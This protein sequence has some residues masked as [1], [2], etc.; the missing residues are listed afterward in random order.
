[1]D[2]K[3]VNRVVV[4]AWLIGIAGIPS[5]SAATLFS[6]SFERTSILNGN[7]VLDNQGQTS[8][9]SAVTSPRFAG[10]YALKINNPGSGLRAIKHQFAAGLRGTATLAFYDFGDNRSAGS[11]F[12]VANQAVSQYVIVL[13]NSGA[14][15][16]TYRI[17]GTALD[18]G[19]RRTAGWHTVEFV[20]TDQGAYVR[21]D[22]QP[23]AHLGIHAGLT[24]LGWVSM[25]RGWGIAGDTY[26]DTVEVLQGVFSDSFERTSILNGNWVLDNQGQTSN[27]SAVTSP[28]FAGTYALKINNPG[29]GLRAI[30]HQ[31]AAGLRGTATLAFYD[32]GD[33]RSAGS[34]FSVANQAVSQYV[35]VLINS[36]ASTY[37]YRI[38]GTALDSGIRRTAGWHTVEFVVTDQGAYVRLD[39]QPL[40]HLGIHAG[41]TELGWVSMGRGWGIAGDTYVDDVRV[42]NLFD[43]PTGRQAQFDNW[44]NEAYRIYRNT[45][46]TSLISNIS[47]GHVSGVNAARGVAGQAM[48]H[49]YYYD[50]D[51]NPDD[52][53]KAKTYIN[54]VID[55]YPAWKQLWGAPVTMN[56]L[57]FDVWW[58]WPLLDSSVRTKFVN[59]LV[60]EANF[61]TWVMN[62]VR[63]NPAGSTIPAE[64]GRRTD[65]CTPNTQPNNKSV[66]T[67]NPN[68]D[69]HLCDSRDEENGWTAQLLATAFSMFP[70]H[71]NAASWNAAA[72]CFAFHTFSAGESAC[73][74]TSRTISNDGLLGNHNLSPSP[75]YTL[76]GLTTLQQG[77]LSYRLAGKSPPSEFLHHTDRGTN[78]PWERNV[79]R[80]MN[81]R[82]EIKSECHAGQ[83]WGD[84]NLH[85][86]TFILDYWAYLSSDSG[87][88]SLL[89]QML[90]YFSLMAKDVIRY[91]SKNPVSSLT[92]YTQSTAD[93]SLQW[94][95]NLERHPQLSAKH[96]ILES[97]RNAAFRQRYF[98]QSPQ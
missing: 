86:A 41:L 78:S 16:Y 89:D 95:V 51:G 13:I 56:Q 2:M 90:R 6:D 88:A 57:A 27:F 97:Y 52:L 91:P 72:R 64:A 25:G 98:P 14:S 18:S 22:G 45:N 85:V 38:Q 81:S 73:G 39:G 20:V 5:A 76:A 7:W 59:I 93:G 62:E 17:Q 71:A 61:W 30:K 15:T 65:S 36:G 74:I 70:T 66:L 55:K 49:L 40:A 92:R 80:C 21:L 10:T 82:Y 47:R 54:T 32:F 33:N 24:E 31:F 9:F 63:F 67:T 19:I 58:A 3:R 8:N 42:L 44:S 43:A 50:R 79:A 1:M 84:R 26:V 48:M 94:F 53:T 68:S 75:L 35:I 69:D 23:L 34:V 11:V 28:R 96:L 87:A 83:D 77:Q 60:E 4:L 37:T 12:S 29:S 46:L